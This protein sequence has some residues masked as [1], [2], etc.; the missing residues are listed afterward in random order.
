MWISAKSTVVVA[1]L[2]AATIAAS[3]VLAQ[4]ANKAS[5]RRHV[6]EIH[7]FKF[8]PADVQVSP[9]DTIVWINR[10]IVPHTITATDKSWD[11]GTIKNEGQWQTVI[12]GDMAGAYYCRFHPAMK[13]QVRIVQ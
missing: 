6:V 9:G 2:A 13:A 1:A 3:L 4:G 5:P 8:I 12:R 10:D 11:S 7:K